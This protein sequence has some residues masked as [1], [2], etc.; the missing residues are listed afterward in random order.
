[1]NSLYTR[2]QEVSNALD[3][4]QKQTLK[5]FSSPAQGDEF[6][7]APGLNVDCGEPCDTVRNSIQIAI[8][9]LQ[10]VSEIS[11]VLEKTLD[12]L[13]LL[14]HVLNT[15]AEL[16]YAINVCL[17]LVYQIEDLRPQAELLA[18][19]FQDIVLDF[20]FPLLNS[21]MFMPFVETFCHLLAFVAQKDYLYR[22]DV[23]FG[24]IYMILLTVG[25]MIVL[26]AGIMSTDLC[27]LLQTTETSAEL[28][29]ISNAGFSVLQSSLTNTSILIPLNLSQST[30]LVASIFPQ[31]F[32]VESTLYDWIPITNA[33]IHADAVVS[34]DLYDQHII[35]DALASLT[36][37]TNITFTEQNVRTCNPDEFTGNEVEVS[38]HKWTAIIAIQLKI[39]VDL[40][41]FCDIYIIDLNNVCIDNMSIFIHRSKAQ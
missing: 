8:E 39:Q 40:F 22:V 21:I 34:S 15:G 10:P 41:F 24:Y 3:S 38:T 31:T 1:M 29:R 36:D 28:V 4:A 26:P 9:A 32:E 13:Q 12:P 7:T 35:D 6:F 19:K 33:V 23:F 14:H 2:H 25:L 11:A 30:G 27:E 16:D 17:E 37:I 18:S 5:V 20:Q